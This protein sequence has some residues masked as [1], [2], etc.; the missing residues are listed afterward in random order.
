MKA[1]K[2]L[3]LLFAVMAFAKVSEAQVD[4]VFWFAAPWVTPSHSDNVPV[5]FRISTFNQTT[6]VRL[7]QPA[8]GVDITVSIPPN[9]LESIDLST[10]INTLEA[11]PA[12]TPLDY[13]IKI[14][15]DTLVTVVYEVL[16]SGN[17]PETYSLKGGNGLGTEFVTPFQT[18]YPNWNMSSGSTQPKQ[19]FN[20]V[21]TENNTTIN[22]TPRTD[23]VGHPAGVTYSITLNAGQVYTVENIY[24]NVN[25]PGRSLAGSIITSNKP[26]SVTISEDS[27]TGVPRTCRDLMG[28]Q[29]VPV[30][31]VGNEYIVNKG[32]MHA[33]VEEGIYVVAT[34]NFTEV[35][36]TDLGGTTTQYLNRGDTWNYTITDPLTFVSSNKNVYVLQASGFGCELGSAILPPINCAGSGQVSFTRS[37]NEGFFLNLLCPTSAVND[38][39]LNGTNTLVPGSL[40]DVVPGTGGAWSGCQIDLS[41][42]TDI[43]VN[44]VN[45]I[46]NTSDFFALGVINGGQSSGT[47]YHYMSSFLRRTIIDAGKD[48]TLC[49]GEP[50]ITLDGTIKGATNTGIWSTLDGTGTFQNATGLNTTYAPTPS[51]YAQGEVSFLLRSTGSCNE[52]TDTMKVNFIQSP[53]V[54]VDADLEYCKNNIPSIVISGNVLFATTGTWSNDGNGGVFGNPNDLTTTYTPSN[55]EINADSVALV[56]TSAGSFFACDNDKDTMVVRFTPAPA[57]D[58]GTDISICSYETEIDLTGVVSGATTTGEWSST[59]NGSFSPSQNDLITSYLID[60]ADISNGNFE[61]ILTSN[62]NQNCLPEY[63]TLLVAITPEPSI[64]ITVDD[65]LCATNTLINLSGNITG[66]FGPEWSTTGFGSIAN[67]N[68]LNTSYTVSPVDT[69]AGYVDFFLTTNG[70]C[71]GQYDSLRV[72]FVKSAVV[73]AGPNQQMCENAAVQLSG[74]INSASPTGAWSSLGTGSFTPGNAF[75]STVYV[76]SAGDVGNGSVQLILESTNNYGCPIA[77]DTL[78]VTFKDI[79][80]A[81]FSVNSICQGENAIFNDNSTTGMGSITNWNWDFGNGGSSSVDDPIHTYMQGGDYNVTL[82]VTGSNDC[83]DTITETLKVNYA[84]IPNFTNSIACEENEIFFTDLSSIPEGSI[85]TWNYDFYGFGTSSDRNPSFSFPIAGNYP[86][87][88]TTVSDAGCSADTTLVVTVIQSPT[89]DFSM[90]PNPALVGETVNFNDLSEGTNLSGWFYDFDDGEAANEQNSSHAYTSGGSYNVYFEVTDGN[91]CKDTIT[92]LIT[93]ELLPVLPSGFTPNGDGEN[94]V[95]IIRGGP[96]KSIDFNIYNNWGELIF[97]SKDQ[98]EGW[99]GT[100]NGEQAP[101]GVYT[102][103]FVVEMGNGQVIKKS[104]DVTLIR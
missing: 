101:L 24:Q 4:S 44:S 28:D 95:F 83:T 77:K 6:S 72:H 91:N 90:N 18:R 35:N 71:S 22:I 17:N 70:V 63:D 10:I 57:V 27:V 69:T 64:D 80:T 88:L 59:G 67:D 40:F 7:Y 87:S 51:D 82:V 38:F 68:A 56:M 94:D 2:I 84:P 53:V 66:G 29:I 31:V 23:V 13:G 9:S 5:K 21:A 16:T 26:I 103:T 79:P 47:Y 32:S 43:P 96:F 61:I 100:Y 99:D 89:A 74:T 75:L 58:A 49:N 1:K 36:I 15:A 37:N 46:E 41:S 30:E 93:V 8:G 54:T 55:T 52:V 39:L 78:T 65:S 97:N 76:P 45:L 11:K 19:M 25:V 102:W 60:P 33:D 62:D 98:S 92:K 3:I 81:D 104:G 86:V 48:T 34:E 85:S 12:D 20:I 14:E 73:N 50:S 42:L